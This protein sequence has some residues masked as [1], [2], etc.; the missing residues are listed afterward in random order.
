MIHY[1]IHY[2]L[3]LVIYLDVHVVI[4]RVNAES[5][6]AALVPDQSGCFKEV[7]VNL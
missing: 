5:S 4:I 2:S 3:S 1:M 6:K 7:F